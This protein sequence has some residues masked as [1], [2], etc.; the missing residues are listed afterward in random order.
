MLRARRD[1][2]RFATLDRVLRFRPAGAG[3]VDLDLGEARVRLALARDGALRICAASGPELPPDLDG[4]LGRDA[5]RPSNAEPFALESGGVVLAFDG[6]DGA[7][8]VEIAEYPLAL[9]IFERGGHQ[10]AR[11]SEL[12][13]GVDG[14]VRIVLSCAEGESFF[15]FG[16]KTGPL[17]KRGRVLR[18][19]NRDHPVWEGVDPLYA[20]IPFFLRLSHAGGV[21]RADGFLLDGAAPSRFDVAASDPSRVTIE[22]VA[23]GLDLTLFPGPRPA[24]VL[25]RYTARTGRI[26]RP[27]LWALGHHQSRWGYRSARKVRRIAQ[28]ARAHRMPTDA[29]HLDI[30]HMDHYRVFTWHPRRFP[31]PAG[32]LAELAAAG[33]RVVTIVDP[34]VKVDPRWKLFRDGAEHDVFLREGDGTP[35]KLKV[36]PRDAA[37]PDFARADV[38]TWWGDLHR[39][40]LEAG[41]AGIWNDMNEPAG[42]KRELRI[43]RLILPLAAQD[44]SRVRQS[45]PADPDH[46]VPHEHLRNAY[47]Q[48]ECRATREGLERIAPNRRPFVLSRSGT[49]GIQRYAALWTGDIQSR[50]EQLRLSVRML[51]G[52]SISGVPF[53]GADIG[54]FHGWC[55]PELFARWIQIGALYPLARTH[56]IWLKHRQEPWRFGRRVEAIARAALERRMWL[57][58]YLYRCFCEAEADGTPVWRPLFWDHP[59]D[60]EAV[61]VQDQLLLGPDLLVAPVLTRGSRRRSV[62]LPTGTWFAL[63]D[64]ARWIG[65]RRI[66]VAAPLEKLPIFARGGSV[67]PTRSPVLHVGETPAE[68]LVLVVHPGGEGATTVIEDDGDSQAYRAGGE[69]RTAVR[70]W[71]RV[72]GRLRLEVAARE[73]DFAV[74]P[75]PLRVALHGCS[76]PAA[77]RLDAVQIPGPFLDGLCPAVGEGETEAGEEELDEP[78]REAPDDVALRSAD[79]DARV[80]G[81]RRRVLDLVARV[82]DPVQRHPQRLLDFVVERERAALLDVVDPRRDHEREGASRVAPME[83]VETAEGVGL[84]EHESHLLPGLA[85]R[86]R[87]RTGIAGLHA[88]AGEGHVPRPRIAPSLGPLDEQHLGSACGIGAVAQHHGDGRLRPRGVCRDLRFRRHQ[89]SADDL[90]LKHGAEDSRTATRSAD[91]GA[92]L[93][94]L[95]A[96]GSRLRLRPR[97]LGSG[98]GGVANP[99]AFSSEV[100]P[101]HEA[102]EEVDAEE[103]LRP[104]PVVPETLGGDEERDIPLLE[105]RQP[106]AGRR[107]G[108]HGLAPGRQLQTARRLGIDGH[109][110]DFGRRPAPGQDQGSRH[111]G[112]DHRRDA[113]PA[114]RDLD[115]RQHVC[116]MEWQHRRLRVRDGHFVRIGIEEADTTSREVDL[117]HEMREER[118]P[119]ERVVAASRASGI[120]PARID[121]QVERNSEAGLAPVR[122]LLVSAQRDAEVPGGAG[123]RITVERSGIE[124]QRQPASARRAE[125]DQDLIRL[126][127]EERKHGADRLRIRLVGARRDGMPRGPQH[128]EAEH[129]DPRAGAPSS[130]RFVSRERAKAVSSQVHE[131]S[132]SRSS[133]RPPAVRR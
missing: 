25:R 118:D 11:L 4:A 44:L 54:G 72:A 80:A 99:H 127:V 130:H 39:P 21:P 83:V 3:G 16:E 133:L 61:A 2:A 115:A 41:V 98:P 78:V 52:L 34:G 123:R 47:G 95:F 46:R 68:P 86:R 19:R 31:D 30:D 124:Q 109:G 56:S 48:L 1:D 59:E 55:S 77:V 64:G 75:R 112:R 129:P 7:L 22:T 90:L 88:P 110:G 12:G 113:R 93:L 53:C 91:P 94:R 62:Y 126:R 20:S 35:Y 117:D 119:D 87:L 66:E 57:L 103:R 45:D 28:E 106:D 63:D 9:R 84:G 97:G 18:M 5:W 128:G 114:D 71:S 92:A 38:R 131:I 70:L 122:R 24:D 10:I 27:P 51:L 14:A 121:V 104:W 26:S 100:E 74:P 58:P 36:W 65:P 49:A 111:A 132:T 15:G 50:W 102:L 81:R 120:T 40:L 60:P 8:R 33:F 13:F 67:I 76:F 23:R 101:Q 89:R 73:G 105:L 29:I 6:P 32:L 107:S 37:L 69:A 79:Q 82:D 116:G 43:G 96:L 125:V 108:Q 17:D 42:W 85:L